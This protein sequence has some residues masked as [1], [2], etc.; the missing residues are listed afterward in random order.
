MT[1]GF[2]TAAIRLFE[3]APET[4]F[5]NRMPTEAQGEIVTFPKL[6]GNQ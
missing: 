4:A 6:K 3:N 5:A 1:E 2:S